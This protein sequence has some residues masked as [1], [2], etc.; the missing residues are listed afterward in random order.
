ML[1]Q[2]N[3][4]IL[5]FMRDMVFNGLNVSIKLCHI[6]F[7]EKTKKL[8]MTNFLIHNWETTDFHFEMYT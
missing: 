3:I 5:L 4:P 1:N 2:D 8:L 7:R 6:G